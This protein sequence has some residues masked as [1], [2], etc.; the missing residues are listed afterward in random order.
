M[1]SKF[2]TSNSCYCFRNKWELLGKKKKKTA[3]FVEKAVD[4]EYSNLD[5][6]PGFHKHEYNILV[7]N[8]II[9]SVWFS[10]VKKL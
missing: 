9:E 4:P 10:P 2:E 5:I 3:R 8:T 6:N 7:F 1:S